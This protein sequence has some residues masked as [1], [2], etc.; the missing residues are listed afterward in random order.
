MTSETEWRER[1][2]QCASYTPIHVYDLYNCLA[3]SSERFLSHW[4]DT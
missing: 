4:G 2:Q 1:E 3:K